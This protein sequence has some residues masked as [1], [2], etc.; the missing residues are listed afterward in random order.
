[1]AQF[2][3]LDQVQAV[4]TP[5]REIN[6]HQIGLLLSNGLKRC[7]VGGGLPADGEI[8]FE[9]DQSSE[10]TAQHG[11]IIDDKNRLL[12]GCSDSGVVARH[13]LDPR[14]F[15]VSRLGEKYR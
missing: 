1:M 2:Y 14:E 12:A 4:S 11:V 6:D 10:P 15:W 13:G 8:G 7:L 3:V 9:I 5:E